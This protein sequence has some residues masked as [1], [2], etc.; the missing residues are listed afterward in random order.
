MC[1]MKLFMTLVHLFWLYIFY[2]MPSTWLMA[3]LV[4]FP[5]GSLMMELYIE[6]LSDLKLS[7]YLI[8]IFFLLPITIYFQDIKPV[9]KKMMVFIYIYCLFIVF[10]FYHHYYMLCI[11]QILQVVSKKAQKLLRDV[12]FTKFT[13][14]KLFHFCSE[15]FHLI[16][17]R[18][19]QK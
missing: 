18:I 4:F 12:I 15:G 9:D 16:S 7:M 10:L 3:A 5:S 8:F 2:F 19:F 14:F 6:Q 11:L 17:N 13:V 1:C